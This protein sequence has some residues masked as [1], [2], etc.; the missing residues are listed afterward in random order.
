MFP[1]S[2]L[3]FIFHIDNIT[4]SKKYFFESVKRILLLLYTLGYIPESSISEIM[5]LLELC[6]VAKK[7]FPYC[8]SILFLSRRTLLLLR[9]NWHFGILQ[10]IMQ[11]I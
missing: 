6:E 4:R 1:G 10:N 8:C 11:K 3:V 5:E 9:S 7:R 2:F